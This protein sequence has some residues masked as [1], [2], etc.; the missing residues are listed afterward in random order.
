[1]KFNVLL[2]MKKF[3]ALRQYNNNYTYYSICQW[4]NYYG[5]RPGGPGG[6][7]SKGAEL[8]ILSISQGNLWITKNDRNRMPT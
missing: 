7:N 8:Q 1:M 4:R 5:L 2:D 3:A 6:P